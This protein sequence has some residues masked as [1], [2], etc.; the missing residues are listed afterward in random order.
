MWCTL[1]TDDQ[2]IIKMDSATWEL[3]VKV[4]MLGDDDKKINISYHSFD[5]PEVNTESKRYRWMTNAS[6][7]AGG[8]FYRKG[9]RFEMKFY[10]QPQDFRFKRIPPTGF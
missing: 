5:V 2:T 7:E 4:T 6:C 3:F 9:Y 10:E 1:L 8:K